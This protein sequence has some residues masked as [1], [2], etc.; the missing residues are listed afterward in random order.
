MTAAVAAALAAMPDRELAALVEAG[1]IVVAGTPV[2]AK[3]VALTELERANPGSTA[4]LFGL[5]EFYQYRLGSS[6]FG[7]WR[8]IAAHEQATAWALAGEC[9]GF[10]LLHHWRVLDVAPPAFPPAMVDHWAAQWE[11]VPAIRTRL[12]AISRATASVVMFS[13]QVPSTVHAWLVAHPDPE[14][15]CALVAREALRI[16][17]F[18]RAHA[19]IHFDMHFHN[20]LTDGTR[21]YLADFG[22]AVSRDFEL[23][24]G[25]LRFFERHAGYDACVV[26]TELANRLVKRFPEARPAWATAMLAHHAPIAD[27]LNAHYDQLRAAKTTPY[28]L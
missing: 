2:F 3:R 9:T 16:A 20:L 24:A 13:E 23:S 4:N 18:L 8:E 1:P 15:A 10:P 25:E 17:A 21:L 28:P 11:N 14:A 6:G 7:V 26:S 12:E 27:A 5:P 19:M 22:L